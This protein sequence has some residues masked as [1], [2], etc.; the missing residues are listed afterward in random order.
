MAEPFEL[1]GAR[2]GHAAHAFAGIDPG[3]SLSITIMA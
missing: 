1:A 2:L 3:N